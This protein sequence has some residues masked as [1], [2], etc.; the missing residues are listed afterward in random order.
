MVDAENGILYYGDYAWKNT[1]GQ[2]TPPVQKSDFRVTSSDM[3]FCGNESINV[4][5]SEERTESQDTGTYIHNFLQ[6]LTLFPS[7]E[8]ERMAVT[9]TESEEIRNRLLQLFERTE[10]DPVLRPYFY[11]DEGDRVLNEVSVITADGN[12]RR[13]D[14]I[15]IK[16]DHVMIID[17]KTGREY[18][19][20]YEAQL[21]EYQ[22]CLLEMGYEDV[23][24]EILYID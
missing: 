3:T 9:A 4:E 22:A 7:T 12:V 15:V 19:A 18:Q 6:K 21:A 16:P 24:T 11:L 14:R 13:P 17:Y 5:L 23:R 1:G 8:E 20:K 10:K 2:M